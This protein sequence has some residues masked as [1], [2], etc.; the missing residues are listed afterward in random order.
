MIHPLVMF[1]LLFACSLFVKH[2]Q[3]NT[4]KQFSDYEFSGNH[5]LQLFTIHLL[6]YKTGYLNHTVVFSLIPNWVF[7]N[8]KIKT[9]E[10]WMHLFDC[11]DPVC[12]PTWA[13]VP[14]AALPGTVCIRVNTEKFGLWGK[15]CEYKGEQWAGAMFQ[16]IE[17][18][19]YMFW[20]GSSSS[21]LPCSAEQ[22]CWFSHSR[23]WFAS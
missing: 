11:E 22:P 23:L 2:L 3:N 9:G 14:R 12:L 16:G 5:S 8:S 10:L 17:P 15:I 6:W 20:M 13:Y 1:W 4:D 18:T 21:A 7:I 19:T